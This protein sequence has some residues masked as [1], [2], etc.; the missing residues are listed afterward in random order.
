MSPVGRGERAECH[1][2]GR[3]WG[4]IRLQA[5]ALGARVGVGPWGRGLGGD[6]ELVLPP[7]PVT[8]NKPLRGRQGFAPHP[9]RGRGPLNPKHAVLG[10]RK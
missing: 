3:F 4:E 1:R 8:L 9:I 6:T 7:L 10:H 5:A 2:L